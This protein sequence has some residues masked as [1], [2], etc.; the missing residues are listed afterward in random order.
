MKNLLLTLLMCLSIKTYSQTEPQYYITYDIVEIF[1]RQDGEWKSQRYDSTDA[2]RVWYTFFDKTLGIIILQDSVT[3]NSYVYRITS[4]H[5]IDE[6]WRYLTKIAKTTEAML[7]FYK[8]ENFHI[9]RIDMPTLSMKYKRR[10]D[11]E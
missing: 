8:D 10:I 4:E 1:D 9:L 2:Y 7:D 11:K 3:K 5:H 6:H